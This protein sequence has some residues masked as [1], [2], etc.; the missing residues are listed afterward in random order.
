MIRT[1]RANKRG[2]HTVHFEPGVNLILADRSTSAGEKDTTNA[3]GKSTL[4]EIIDFCLGSNTPPGKGLRVDALQGW[5]FTLELSLAGQNVAVTRATQAP[6]FFAIEGLTDGW[7]FK[8]AP[9]KENVPGLDT[10]KWRSVLAWA[11]FGISEPASDSGYKPSARSLI[12]Y[13]VRNQAA[14][15]NAP[16]KYFDNQKT[17]DIQLHN[18]FLLGLNWEKVLCWDRRLACSLSAR[19]KRRIFQ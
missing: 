19:R 7:P 11:L 5:A 10:K 3:L 14:A 18:A 12:S 4:I 15:Y 1:V 13:F 17:W 16:F 2:F 9:N 6:G 8:P